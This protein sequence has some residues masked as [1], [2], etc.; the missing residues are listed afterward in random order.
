MYLIHCSFLNV[1]W[2]RCF[3]SNGI[4]VLA[5]FL[6][7]NSGTMKKYSFFFKLPFVFF[8]ALG[9]GG[10]TDLVLSFCLMVTINP[11]LIFCRVDTCPALTPY[12][13]QTN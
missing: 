10:G 5:M 12:H 6:N 8:I 9:E 13:I 2:S 3:V 11:L 1:R 4:F 7:Q